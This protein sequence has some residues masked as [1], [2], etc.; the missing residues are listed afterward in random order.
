ME[1]PSCVIDDYVSRWIALILVLLFYTTFSSGKIKL[2]LVKNEAEFPFGILEIFL[3][4]LRIAFIALIVSFVFSLEQANV[5]IWVI[6]AVSVVLSILSLYMSG[7]FFPELVVKHL[8]VTS[9]IFSNFTLFVMSPFK[10]PYSRL[11]KKYDYEIDQN[12]S[13][14]EEQVIREINEP[15]QKELI[16]GIIEFSATQVCEIMTKRESIVGIEFNCT[17]QEALNKA[18]ESGFSRIP[19]FKDSFDEI[20]G[21]LYIKDMLGILN[22]TIADVDWHGLVRG[23]HFTQCTKPIIELLDELRENKIHLAIVLDENELCVGLVTMED[24]IE[25]IVGEISDETDNNL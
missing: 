3:L 22:G 13:E 8:P 1:P 17:S 4:L 14:S 18:V 5:G 20:V 9:D 12:S 2:L 23:A 24:I 16:K 25:E 21:F 10:K 19:V 15:E 7:N 11:M 6:S